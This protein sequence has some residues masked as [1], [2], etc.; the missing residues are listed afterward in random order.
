MR[1]G[2]EQGGGVMIIWEHPRSH[3]LGKV[4]SLGGDGRLV[5][6]PTRYPKLWRARKS[7]LLNQD[8][9]LDEMYQILERLVML[10]SHCMAMGLLSPQAH[11][12]AERGVLIP[13]R[14][15]NSAK[16]EG[17][18]MEAAENLLV[19]DIDG[20][21][22]TEGMS[23]ADGGDAVRAVLPSILPD[24]LLG[25]DLIYQ[26]TGSIMLKGDKMRLRLFFIL[27]SAITPTEIKA[28]IDGGLLNRDGRF[29][30]DRSL[31]DAAK[32][33]LTAG[34]QLKGGLID[35]VEEA[36]VTRMGLLRLGRP[37]ATLP[38]VPK[39]KKPKRGRPRAPIGKDANDRLRADAILAM[40]K[41]ISNASAAGSNY[42]TFRALAN[43][44]GHW[45]AAGALT[46]NEVSDAV[47]YAASASGWL[48]K[49]G[50]EDRALQ[51]LIRDS[52]EY[53]QSH[54]IERFFQAE[55]P[56]RD[57]PTS[58]E[59]PGSKPKQK[60][61][62]ASSEQEIND[63]VLRVC[64]SAVESSLLDRD[65]ISIVKIAAGGGKSTA[66]C[67]IIASIS[68][69]ADFD[70][71]VIAF[72][73]YQLIQE[74]QE[75][76]D[77]LGVHSVVRKGKLRRCKLW[78]EDEGERQR[79]NNYHD[80]GVSFPIVCKQIRC[81]H[82]RGC[83]IAQ[84][85]AHPSI[86]KQVTLTTHH[87][88]TSGGFNSELEDLEAPPLFILDESPQLLIHEKVSLH[89]LTNLMIEPDD[90]KGFITKDAQWRIDR[91]DLSQLAEELE[92]VIRERLEPLVRSTGGSAEMGDG[93]L[94][95]IIANH[96]RGQFI[97]ALAQKVR[98]QGAADES[99]WSPPFTDDRL[100]QIDL[101]AERLVLS[102]SIKLIKTLISSV[103]DHDQRLLITAT[104]TGTAVEINLTRMIPI[105]LPPAPLIVLDATPRPERWRLIAKINSRSRIIS[106]SRLRAHPL[107]AY[108]LKSG[109]YAKSR[110]LDRGG[111]S[112]RAAG[113]FNKLAALIDDHDQ[114]KG[115][116]GV[117]CQAKAVSELIELG[118]A[119][120]GALQDSEMI[121]GL[122]NL[123][124]RGGSITVGY[125]GRDGV[126]TSRF[127]AVDSMILIGNP[128]PNL[129]V[130]KA[131]LRAL[132]LTAQEDE[133]Q[134]TE[135][136]ELYQQEINLNVTQAV[137][138]LRHI[139]REGR[140]LIYAGSLDGLS[141]LIETE[142]LNTVDLSV[143][144]A[145]AGRP[146]SNGAHSEEIIEAMTGR[147]KRG[148]AVKLSDIKRLTSRKVADT[149]IIKKL[150]ELPWVSIV[151]DGTEKTLIAR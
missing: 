130:F 19:L 141:N 4:W 105:T 17:S 103:L 89:G 126:G 24:C 42:L 99:Y 11:M 94:M 31:Y 136:E 104:T 95:D 97:Q 135:S 107:K 70:G 111:L 73:D 87:Y 83:P 53:T 30:A 138:R 117:L 7:A 54:P 88:V 23:L 121:R 142:Y 71:V 74:A 78:V 13:R 131:E 65:L 3:H 52:L 145:K 27:E 100:K 98:D 45:R 129:T 14:R 49:S 38:P 8:F 36:G 43:H 28:L 64:N 15:Y 146:V 1:M 33:I 128:A 16:N 48:A 40:E 139:R 55:R 137:G 61:R 18:V 72:R 82:A 77:A 44:L 46:E 150:R 6:E 25:V 115:K 101:E 106:N 120:E 80:H 2:R 118:L 124:D 41:G 29:H 102:P 147:L 84:K 51:R 92:G 149:V 68:K 108:Q 67:N 58:R 133:L 86:N 26:F 47:R 21:E 148:E 39:P 12:E 76:L 91:P 119:G 50:N 35:P 112:K 63:E 60:P 62:E 144:Q 143:R 22:W 123:K 96:E 110:L 69:S 114:F 9:T 5:S 151:T 59:S 66:I 125:Y 75:R 116:V 127:E 134:D 32:A 20:A 37:K 132:R 81:P 10:P 109:Q 90:T 113:A 34:P 122:L 56:F 140:V 85:V 57:K 93:E 79:I